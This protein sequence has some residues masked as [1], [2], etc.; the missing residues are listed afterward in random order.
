MPGAVGMNVKLLESVLAEGLTDAQRVMLCAI[1][2]AAFTLFD[3]DLRLL[4]ADGDAVRAAYPD[5]QHEVEGRLL[6][7]VLGPRIERLLDAYREAIAGRAVE[8]D[9]DYRRRT[10]WVHVAPIFDSD[11]TVAA[12]LAISIDVTEQRRGEA[13]VDRRAR[14]QSAL[15]VLGRLALD[16]ASEG[17]L[18]T[19]GAEAIRATLGVDAVSVITLDEAAGALVLRAGAGWPKEVI[20]S[21]RIPITDAHRRALA[22]L[23]AGPEILLDASQRDPDG[24]LIAALGAASMVTALIGRGR[25]ALR[26]AER[27]QLLAP[28]VHRRGRRLPAVDGQHPVECDRAR[29]RRRR[30]PALRPVRRADRAAQPAPVRAAP[31]ARAARAR[32][33]STAGS[34]CCCSTSTT[35]RSSTTASATVGGD[36]LLRA[37]APRLLGVARDGDT[38]ARLGGDEFALVCEGIVS[39]E[40][41][42]E[43]AKRVMAALAES[44]RARAPPPVSQGEHRRRRRR[45]P[46]RLPAAAARRRHRDA[47]RQGTR[48]RLRRALLHR[49]CVSAWWR[50]CAPSPSCTGPS[51]AT[52]CACYFQPFF[53]IPDRRLLGMEALVRW[54]HPH[55]GLVL[56][57]EFIPLAEQNGQIVELGEWVLATAASA[58]A[59]WRSALAG[60]R[61]ADR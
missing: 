8:L 51:S 25:P 57:G 38:V 3:R 40:H 11:G 31:G 55:R 43:V 6:E 39:E 53:S 32:S 12:G 61:R 49:R 56:P 45:R 1:P 42:L 29:R 2:G 18:L 33:A 50:A 36:E 58:L 34:R 4:F 14:G 24:P 59:G 13:D 15:A 23:Q 54:Q 10:Y 16:G 19:E 47:P 48:W 60:E 52:S 17:R 5:P 41:A 46:T 26:H 30:V 44:D 27:V 21:T 20:R 35:S 22:A 7:D 28:P 37:L 9:L